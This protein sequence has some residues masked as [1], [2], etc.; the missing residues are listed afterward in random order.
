MKKGPMTLPKPTNFTLSSAVVT[1]NGQKKENQKDPVQVYCR[2][3]PLNSLTELVV[4]RKETNNILHITHPTGTKNDL[5]FNFKNIFSEVSTQKEIFDEVAYPLVKDLINGKDGQYLGGILFFPDYLMV[6]YF[7]YFIQC[8]PF[9]YLR[10]H[11]VRKDTYIDREST[12]SG[13]FVSFIGH[14][15]QYDSR[16]SMP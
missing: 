10:H 5:Y 2:I 8:R 4:L 13:H 12:K 15:F 9:V 7:L 3:R 11:I 1:A 6:F 14:H 16:S